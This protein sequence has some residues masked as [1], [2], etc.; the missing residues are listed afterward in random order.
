MVLGNL[1]PLSLSN[2]Y[3]QYFTGLGGR[4]NEIV[5]EQCLVQGPPV[6]VPRVEAGCPLKMLMMVNPQLGRERTKV[7]LGGREEAEGLFVLASSCSLF[8]NRLTDKFG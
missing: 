8:Q 6:G 1:I 4:L 3:Q 2:G 7:R 5:C